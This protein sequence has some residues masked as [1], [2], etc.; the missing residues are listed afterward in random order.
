MMIMIHDHGYY[1]IMVIIDDGYYYLDVISDHDNDSMMMIL[2]T[3]PFLSLEPATSSTRWKKCGRA[4]AEV[5]WISW[6]P[7]NI[8]QPHDSVI[9]P[10]GAFN[11]KV[12]GLLRGGTK[13]SP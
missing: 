13:G 9:I 7:R 5:G 2:T 4:T 10:W 6:R 11:S 8:Q 3:P 12:I 1:F